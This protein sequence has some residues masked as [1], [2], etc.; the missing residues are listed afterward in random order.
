MVNNVGQN[1]GLLSRL[2]KYLAYLA[3]WDRW[4]TEAINSCPALGPGD[5]FLRK[6]K[7]HCC[8][9]C[10]FSRLLPINC[11]HCRGW[12]ILELQ[13]SFPLVGINCS[14]AFSFS[15]RCGPKQTFKKHCAGLEAKEQIGYFFFIFVVLFYGKIATWVMAESVII[16]GLLNMVLVKVWFMASGPTYHLVFQRLTNTY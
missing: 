6:E 11:S 2:T 5:A 16:F 8:K 3:D 10:L 1:F 4:D 7:P 12:K 14:H 13:I 15:L 9:H